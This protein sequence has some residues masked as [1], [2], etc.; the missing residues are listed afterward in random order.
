[1]AQRCGADHWTNTISD[2]PSTSEMETVQ[3]T[4]GSSRLLPMVRPQWTRVTV[5]VIYRSIWVLHYVNSSL[6]KRQVI[7]TPRSPEDDRS[8]GEEQHH[9]G[10]P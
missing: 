1:M 8:Q 6:R 10:F 3:H 9:Q 2:T 7:S 4:K 5:L